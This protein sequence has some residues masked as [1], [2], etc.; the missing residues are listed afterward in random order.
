MVSWLIERASENYRFGDAPRTTT[1]ARGTRRDATP[2]VQYVLRRTMSTLVQLVSQQHLLS[3]VGEHLF[4]RV[5]I[6]SGTAPI[7][8]PVSSV[9]SHIVSARH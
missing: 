8:E 5:H 1:E 2:Q 7:S 4:L 3:F 6:V 9:A